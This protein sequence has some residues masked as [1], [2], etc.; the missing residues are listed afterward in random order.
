MGVLEGKKILITGVLTDAS[1]AFGVARLAIEEGAEVILTGAGRG[2]GREH[3]L[4]FGQEGAKVVVNDLGGANDGEGSDATPAQEVAAEIR[5]Q[6]GEARVHLRRHLPQT[7]S[8]THRG[9][10]PV[11]GC[12]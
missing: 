12:R 9:Q 5:A 11:H 4:L 2:L 8:S 7:V 10:R 1:L 6:G 3:A